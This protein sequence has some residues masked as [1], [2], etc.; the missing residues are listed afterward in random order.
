M[1]ARRLMPQVMAALADTPVV[2]VQGPRQAGKTTL[3][4]MVRGAGHEAEY[5]T[6]DDAADRASAQRDPDGFIA[7]LPEQV[8][9][10]EIQRAPALFLAIKASVDRR[11]KP[12]R[13][14]LTGSAHALVLPTVAD[15]LAGRMEVLTLRP[16]SQGEI[17]GSEEVFVDACFATTFA[18]RRVEAAGWPDLVER[19]VRGGFPTAQARADAGRR[20]AWFA[21]YTTTILDRDLR[22]LAN[23]QHLNELPRL[24]RLVAAR[25]SGVLNLA[26]LARD[27]GIPP[28]T[29]Q[30]HWAMLEAIFFVQAI[31]AW[32]GNLS[33]RLA[34][35][36]KAL[37]C[38][39]GLLCYLLNLDAG[40]LRE[41]DLM[42]GAALESFVACEL[43]KQADW[44]ETRPSLF[45][46]RTHKQQE[47]DFVLEDR[48]GRLVGIEVKK[49]ASPG[50]ADFRGLRHLQERAGKRFLRGFMLYTG[51]ESV[52]FGPDLYALPVS[53]LWSGQIADVA[54]SR[55]PL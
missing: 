14:L 2:F 49:T 5:R 33:S 23:V 48:R 11:R 42:T 46:Y 43:V 25:S 44:S 31:P 17:A 6:L 27:A 51:T 38:D 18:P 36:P 4:E 41:D 1:K 22:D 28:S 29:L 54:H 50:P 26:D 12:G 55:T 8:V 45:H 53:A 32:S 35:A 47:V 37:V 20:A 10:D 34:K 30:R 16:F 40:R 39:S 15:S 3:V 7:A 52:A 21:S 19:I 24:L 9:L 13:F